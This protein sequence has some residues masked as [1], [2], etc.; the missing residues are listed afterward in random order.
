MITAEYTIPG[1][2]V[3]DHEVVVPLKWWDD[4]NSE[5]IT[6]FARELVDPTRVADDMPYLV[7]LQG[8]PGGK[9]PRPLA[10]DGWIGEAL[11]S[12]RVVLL[13]QRGTGRS[14]NVQG[15]TM[16]RFE[17]AEAGADYLR[18]F[19]AD[20]IVADAEHL[21]KTV[22]G[23]KPW[24]TLGQSY[25][26]FLTLTYLSQAP[27]GL[28]A[29]YVTGGLASVTPDAAEVYRRTF[30]RTEAKNREFYA[31]FP[32]DEAQLARI[33]DRL[34]VGDVFLPDGDLLTVRRLQTVGIDFGMKPGFERV[35]WLIDEAFVGSDGDE[36]SDTFLAQVANLTSHASAPLFAALQES[37]YGNE[38]A[39]ATGWAAQREIERLPQFAESARPLLLTGEMMFPWMFDEIRALKPFQPAVEYLSSVEDWSRLYDLDVLA[40]NEVPVAA[41]VYFDDMYVDSGLQLET[42]STVGNT[43]AWVTNEFEHD[44]IGSPTVFPYLR[45]YVTSRGGDTGDT[46]N[47]GSTG[48]K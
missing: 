39:G 1:L 24:S 2:R 43:H 21:R 27:E 45:N 37:I 4:R 23:G 11:K 46:S 32:Q 47:N 13:D 25:G 44:G 15:R 3:A 31:R 19:R 17:T 20:S 22:F 35:H 33:A 30:P 48:G 8:G 42:A 36:L 16:E 26:G 28:R 40:R 34:S 12:Y 7:F 38:G 5:T 10:A 29:C 18:C 41:A 6:V 14:S 9:G